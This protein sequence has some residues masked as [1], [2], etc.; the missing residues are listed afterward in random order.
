MTTTPP[1][2]PTTA[3]RGNPVPLIL[4]AVVAL[5]IA[6]GL[7]AMLLAGGGD[8]EVLDEPVVI[9]DDGA[10]VNT[11]TVMATGEAAPDVSF[12]YFDGSEGTLDDFAGQ[13]VVLNFFA[14][15]CAPCVAEMPGMQTVSEEYEDEVAFLGMNTR[16]VQERGEAIAEE[17]GVE[18]TLARDPS[19]SVFLAF[20]ALAMPTTVFIDADGNVG[21]VW[22]GEI[23]ADELRQVIEQELLA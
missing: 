20:D 12:V 9:G 21:R 11:A 23:S 2:T 7:V 8:E 10:P 18:Y 14:S 15:W 3:E 17:T 4:A 22:S 1:S 5:V 16:D 19:G 6:G 13:P